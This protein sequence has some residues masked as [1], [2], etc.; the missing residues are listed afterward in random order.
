VLVEA[1]LAKFSPEKNTAL[2]IGV[3][4]GVHLGHKHLIA[5]LLEEARQEQLLSGVVT[6]RQ[7]PEDLLNPKAKLP[8]LTDMKARTGFLKKEGVDM[9]IPLSF[10]VEL[11]QL[12][13]RSFMSL[14]QKH[15]RMRRLVIGADFALGKGR[16][17]DTAALQK[18]GKEKDFS[19]TVVPPLMIDGEVVS[20]TAIRQAM[21]AGDMPRVRKLAGHYFSL[22]GK[23]VPG[24]GRGEG[25]GFPTANLHVSKGQALPP[26]GVYTSWAHINGNSY[27]SLTNVGKCPTFDS[28]ERTIETYVIDYSGDLYGNDLYVDLVGKLREEKRFESIDELKAQITDDIKQ[29]RKILKSAGLNQP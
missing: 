21:A 10:N 1:E 29:G 7:H 4:D 26:D 27:Q 9:V 19:V 13:A 6:F 17:G 16:E 2:T 25:L 24:T 20:S 3:F 8:F 23:V 15:L 18:L 11:A 22:H 28:S 12:D 5:R 14:L